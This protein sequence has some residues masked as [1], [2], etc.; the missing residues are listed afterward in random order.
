MSEIPFP[1]FKKI[2]ETIEDYNNIAGTICEVELLF[3]SISIKAKAVIEIDNGNL[4]ANIKNGISQLIKQKYFKV[5]FLNYI[6]CKAFV[7][8][9][10]F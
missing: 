1:D 2:N 3:D 7:V 4:Y 9:T 8:E 10:K 5:K 6:S